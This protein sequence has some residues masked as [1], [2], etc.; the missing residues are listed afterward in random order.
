MNHLTTSEILQ[1]VA[2]G[3]DDS[4]HLKSCSV[5]TAKAVG[6]AEFLSAAKYAKPFEGAR[7]ANCLSIEEI[8]EAMD[9]S[10]GEPSR[11]E[12]ARECPHC[13]QNAAYYFTESNRMEK[14]RDRIA[15]RRF[16]DAA[17][18]IIPAKE[19]SENI[20]S[21]LKRWVLIPLP[22]Y[23]AAV[24]LISFMLYTPEMSLVPGSGGKDFVIY[25]KTSNEMPYFY[26]GAKGERI[27]S[28]DA[29]MITFLAGENV[30]FKWKEVEGVSE[31]FF[32]LQ[33]TTDVAPRTVYQQ[34]TLKTDL[35]VK[36]GYLKA[37][38]SYRWIMAG[39]LPPDSYFVGEASFAVK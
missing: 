31:Y 12:H 10:G 24:L 17:L 6:M 22:A 23:A 16:V 29:E 37:G 18:G 13:F 38:R 27:G 32:V 30:R 8:A 26:F 28:A 21:W 14:A 35:D 1:I 25:K 9:S 7:G 33:D 36:R 19:N 11:M 4:G 3:K 34:S 15:P 5:C 2:G 20:L 39:G